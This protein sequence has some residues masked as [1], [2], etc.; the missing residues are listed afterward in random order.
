MA[1]DELI[2]K[3]LSNDL[4]QAELNAFRELDDYDSNTEILEGAKQ[5]KASK[6]STVDSYEV[7]KSRLNIEKE[8]E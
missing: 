7:L 3:W 8:S 1:Q 6:F 4:N 2:K 5:F